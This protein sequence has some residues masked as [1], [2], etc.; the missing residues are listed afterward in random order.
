[1]LVSGQSTLCVSEWAE[2]QYMYMYGCLRS[3]RSQA[4]LE[5]AHFRACSGLYVQVRHR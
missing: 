4:L 2:W 5:N 3:P 1:M